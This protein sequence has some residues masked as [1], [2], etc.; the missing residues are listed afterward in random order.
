MCGRYTVV[1]DANALR[2]R[3]NAEVTGNYVKRYNAAP[4]QLLP[5]ITAVNP[6]GFSFFYWGLVPDWSKNKAISTKLINARADTIAEKISFR[7]ALHSRRCLVPADSFYEW[8]NVTK[9]SKIPY[10]FILTDQQPFAFAGLW[11]EYENELQEIVHTFTIITTDANTTVKPIHDR[12]PVILTPE[13]ERKWL[14]TDSSEEDLLS[15]LVPYPANEMGHYA[16]SSK[17]NN[18]ANDSP[19]LIEPAA[20]ADQFGNYSLFD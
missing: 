4:G 17:V 12:M 1:A 18:P 13:T 11:E 16:V 3:F 10:R 7:S 6:Q 8:K 14:D 20:A 15:L 19:D 5:V 2:D 9:K